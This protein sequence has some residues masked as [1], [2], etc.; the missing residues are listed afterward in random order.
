MDVITKAIIIK[1]IVDVVLP[2]ISKCGCCFHG[3]LK[4]SRATPASDSNTE[5]RGISIKETEAANK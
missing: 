5:L 4:F 3:N 1:L 2:I